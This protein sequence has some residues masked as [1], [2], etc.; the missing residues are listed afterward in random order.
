VLDHPTWDMGPKITVDSAT[1]M[2]KGLE[3]LEAQLLFGVPLSRID[4]VIHR[5]SIVH[6]LV[7]MRDGAFLA[8][9]GAPDMRVPILFALSGGAHSETDVA[10][11]SPLDTP[12]LH[13]E[14]PDPA[15]YPCL[16]LAR[17]AGETA[18]AAPIVLNAANEEAVAGLLRGSLSFAD[19]PRVIE[20][21]LE[22]L[23]LTGVD[24]VDEA[25]ARDAETR[26]ACRDLVGSLARGRG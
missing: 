6:S 12:T 7:E 11:W 3:V 16:G 10:P 15:R 5:E 8:Q 19:I 25:L 18:G 23:S 26:V 2:N 1:M 13:F 22:R 20:T 17:R 21:A 24:S 4:V 14:T 9:M